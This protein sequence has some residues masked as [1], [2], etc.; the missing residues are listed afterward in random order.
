MDSVRFGSLV[1]R[2]AADSRAWCDDFVVRFDQNFSD[3]HNQ[4]K[5]AAPA[6]ART[7]NATVAK[8]AVR[9]RVSRYFPLRVDGR[10][11][12]R[13][14]AQRHNL[15]S[16]STTE[17]SPHGHAFKNLTCCATADKR[18]LNGFPA[19]NF[20]STNVV[21]CLNDMEYFLRYARHFKETSS[22]VIFATSTL[23]IGN[24]RCNRRSKMGFA[25]KLCVILH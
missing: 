7:E 6:G 2:S 22:N 11:Q 4:Q 5:P 17:A 3:N 15:S 10:L 16:D 14:T 23:L 25:S 21:T 13:R 20:N 12:L 19:Q 24:T 9:R 1:M 8:K 18:P